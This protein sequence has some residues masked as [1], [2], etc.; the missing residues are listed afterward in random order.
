ML[1]SIENLPTSGE[2][3]RVRIRSVT[4][5]SAPPGA[6]HESDVVYEEGESD[7]PIDIEDAALRAM[8]AESD[9]FAPQRCELVTE[10]SYNFSAGRITIT[11]D[12]SELLDI[13]GTLT[14]VTFRKDEPGL[15]AIVRSGTIKSMFVLEEGRHHTCEYDVGFMKI[16]MCF[17]ARRV[18]NTV[19][20]GKGVIE[21]DYTVEMNGAET[22]RTKLE[23]T[24][25]E[26]LSFRS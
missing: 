6:F 22:Q 13:P 2:S 26:G 5:Q 1:S 18:R 4:Y 11:Y 7:T 19:S 20:R 14:Q 3:V 12:E 10:G 23:I 8:S 17:Y 25:G 16:P 15:V 21:L 9:P 24:V